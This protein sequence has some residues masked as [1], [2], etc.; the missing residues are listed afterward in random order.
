MIEIISVDGRKIM[1]SK[2]MIS[3]ILNI[4]NIPSGTYVL[5]IND[6]KT[7]RTKRLIRM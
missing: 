4:S 5:K 3:E 6:G 1:E 2:Q 7:L